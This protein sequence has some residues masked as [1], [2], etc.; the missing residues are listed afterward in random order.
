MTNHTKSQL[1]IDH[2][3]TAS[4]RY[5]RWL[6]WGTHQRYI[7]F[8]LGFLFVAYG[9]LTLNGY[10][11][12]DDIYRMI[13]T[14]RSLFSEHRYVPSRFQ[15]Y[16][17]PEMV[18][19]LSSQLGDFYL[20]NLVSTLQAIAG[21]FFFYRLL[22][23]VTSPFTAA[24]A[25]ALAGVNPYWI[26]AATTSTDYIYPA[27]F[28]LFGLWLLLN[29][30]LRWAGIIFACAVSSRIT[31]GPMVAIAFL[32]YGLTM[33]Q[34]LHQNRTFK[35]RFFQAIGLFLLACIALYMPIFLASGM[36]L[37]FLKYAPDESGLVGM[38]ARFFYKN[39]YFWGVPAVIAIGIAILQAKSFYWKQIRR[40]PFRHPTPNQCAFHGVLLCFIY[41]E[42][43]FAK[44]PHQY[45][46]LIPVLFCISYFLVQLP[47]ARYRTIFLSLIIGFQVL[48]CGV[49]FDVLETYQTGDNNRT[50]HSDGAFWNP[51]IK[52]GILVRDYQW[53]S[54]Y[55]RQLTDDFNQRW[56]HFG[57]P[58]QNPL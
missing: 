31:Y 3:S 26:I 39:V 6:E 1:K 2:H 52:P 20:S 19:G 22:L 16:L 42:L 49:N 50:V 32:F 58:L 8:F 47:N 17:V 44:L 28:F 43:F 40:F 33:Q 23:K 45:Q 55:Q 30:R 4:P 41:N 53:R 14:W 7:L 48:H 12:H 10:G 51:S 56:Q 25:T 21:L 9:L 37:S 34:Q 5:L 46:Y 27:F 11:N 57:R 29:D 38:A 15:G 35:T 24:L 18:I 13:G 54:R 36:T